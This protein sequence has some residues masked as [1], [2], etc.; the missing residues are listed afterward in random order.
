MKGTRY[1]LVAGRGA[2]ALLRQRVVTA[3]VMLALLYVVTAWLPTAGFAAV[4]SVVMLPAL[5]EWVRLMGLSQ[6]WQRW[7]YAIL[8]Y[9]LIIITLLSS[10]P[11]GGDLSIRLPD[12]DWMLTMNG[13]AVL[14]WLF[15][16]AAIRAF[17]Q[18]TRFWDTPRVLGPAGLLVLLP[19][20]W[21]L[22]YLKQLDERGVLVFV[23]I[24]LV[25]VVDIGAY[26]TGQTWGRSKLA[27]ALS[28]NKSWAGFWGGLVAGLVL[29]LILIALVHVG[30]QALHPGIWG[31]LLVL[32]ALL[33]VLSVLGDLFESMLKRQRGLKD[34]G[35]SLPG[36]GGLLDRVDSLLAA[37]P[38]FTLGV[39]FLSSRVVWL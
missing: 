21:N 30:R 3:V 29:A 28:P 15:V 36:H 1:R 19:A 38:V 6:L 23:L 14:F 16:F 7:C 39:W 9:L 11:S 2:E 10:S 17:P 4:L 20:W 18:G 34:S 27:P 25:S 26:F 22:V 8:F 35:A 31:G 32:A 24:A 13:V 37:I 33:A 5:F 12:P